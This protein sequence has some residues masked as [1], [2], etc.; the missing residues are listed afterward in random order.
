MK[1]GMMKRV[2]LAKYTTFYSLKG[3]IS[4]PPLCVSGSRAKGLPLYAPN[5]GRLVIKVDL[6]CRQ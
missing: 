2:R 1:T 5:L 4:N 6:P 3:Y